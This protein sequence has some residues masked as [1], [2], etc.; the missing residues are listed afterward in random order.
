[1]LSKT[2]MFFAIIMALMMIATPFFVVVGSN[3]SSAIE[4]QDDSAA[5]TTVGED[6]LAEIFA[7]YKE[8]LENIDV[9]QLEALAEGAMKTNFAFTYFDNVEV[10]DIDKESDMKANGTYRLK[11]SFDGA[12]SWTVPEG[13]ALIVDL[14]QDFKLSDFTLT[15]KDDA[16]FVIV[17]TLSENSNGK[18][19]SGIGCSYTD[20]KELEGTTAIKFTGTLTNVKLE[21]AATGYYLEVSEGAILEI[22]DSIKTEK[23]TFV[24]GLTF[25]DIIAFDLKSFNFDIL[26]ELTLGTIEIDIEIGEYHIAEFEM[27][28]KSK[29]VINVDP[30]VNDTVT[31][32]NVTAEV[33]EDFMMTDGEDGSFELIINSNFTAE[34]NFIYDMDNVAMMVL[35]ALE[36]LVA[37]GDFNLHFDMC[38]EMFGFE[39][40]IKDLDIVD[41][42]DITA[43]DFTDKLT[44]TVDEIKLAQELDGG[45]VVYV[46]ID[47]VDL[48]AVVTYEDDEFKYTVGGSITFADATTATYEEALTVDLEFEEEGYIP[49]GFTAA[50][51]VDVKVD[52]ESVYQSGIES[53]VV[54]FHFEDGK[55]VDT[56]V[57]ID[58]YTIIS[59]NGVFLIEEILFADDIL[60]IT[61]MQTVSASDEDLEFFNIDSIVYNTETTDLA[62]SEITMKNLDGDQVFD[63]KGITYDSKTG[64]LTIGETTAEAPG[65]YFLMHETTYDANKKVLTLGNVVVTKG[66]AQG[67]KVFAMTDAK[68]E[69]GL[70]GS[71]CTITVKSILVAD[72]TVDEMGYLA[73][74]GGLKY[75]AGISSKAEA[76][77]F[78]IEQ[79]NLLVK[80]PEDEYTTSYSLTGVK[81]AYGVSE[82]DGAAY[83]IAFDNLTIK[84][85]DAIDTMIRDFYYAFDITSEGG[86]SKIGATIWNGESWFSVSAV[87]GG[88]AKVEKSYQDKIAKFSLEMSTYASSFFNGEEFFTYECKNFKLELGF[89]FNK[90]EPTVAKITADASGKILGMDVKVNGFVVDLLNETTPFSISSI[91]IK[92]NVAVALRGV[93]LKSVDGTWSNVTL[94]FHINSENELP[95]EYEC[96]SFKGTFT[97][98]NGGK[99]VY[100][101]DGKKYVATVEATGYVDVIDAFV[102]DCEVNVKGD[103]ALIFDTLYVDSIKSGKAYVGGWLNNLVEADGDVYSVTLSGLLIGYNAETKKYFAYPDEGYDTSLDK[104]TV[105]AGFTMDPETKEVTITGD[106]DYLMAKNAPRNFIVTV[107][108]ADGKTIATKDAKYDEQVTISGLPVTTLWLKDSNNVVY[109]TVIFAG[110]WEYTYKALDNLELT[111]VVG[112]VI[113]ISSGTTETDASAFTFEVPIGA[114]APITVKQTTT[115][116][117]MS[118]LPADYA[119]EDVEISAEKTKYNGHDAYDI[120]AN[121]I[122]TVSFP[123]SSA[124]DVLYHVVNGV[125]V[126]VEGEYNETTKTIDATLYNYSTYYVGQ[127]NGGGSD[128][129]NN[130]TIIIV[131][132][133]IAI[134]VIGAAAYFF[135][136]KQ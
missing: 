12:I 65:Y 116:L 7:K 59:M 88:T 60:T 66:D 97:Y 129:G 104:V 49:V 25:K 93:S 53:C 99:A 92:G 115:N 86:D 37:E 90:F 106:K 63:L 29:T 74:I 67:G 121:G 13:A 130:T 16:S 51:T 81:Y 58:N 43:D 89:D 79:F 57:D 70:V 117:T 35:E 100:D 96:E 54:S 101:V 62:I 103:G 78:E 22:K 111:A 9:E 122:V 84:E 3:D 118:F 20:L 10:T 77:A 131:A 15:L 69:L 132:V 40:D 14:T 56:H 19:I 107:K 31:S 94:Q 47:D 123:A 68:V 8:I 91:T 108:D 45:E 17:Y 46:D 128:G 110:E 24:D 39:Y 119:L 82:T 32:L 48:D 98:S 55:L 95:V 36:N 114:T 6:D 41:E 42:I 127:E 11:D 75:V 125:A 38:L 83:A 73:T 120:H 33:S 4:K 105:V 2:K 44:L 26:T 18:T 126:P 23:A 61:N 133:I 28:G 64:I 30:N 52:G 72:G 135:M 5:A 21:V 27:T 87:G 76:D 71:M 134:V 102:E 136:R 109:G 112:K 85:G 1:M 80:D 113:P 34:T 50:W 124:D